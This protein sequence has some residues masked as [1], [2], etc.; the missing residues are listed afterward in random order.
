MR[1]LITSLRRD[2]SGVALVM[3][4]GIALIG[5]AVAGIVVTMA[6]TA[7]N[8]SGRDRTRTTEIH[9]AEGAVDATMAELGYSS[10]CPKPTFS[11]ITS[12]NGAQQ[13][14]VAVTIAYF[15]GAGAITCSA[16][17]PSRIPTTAVITATSTSPNKSIGLQPVRKLQAEVKLTPR[18]T[19]GQDAAVF[20]QGNFNTDAAFT[21]APA[22]AGQS[23]D[24]WV[25]SGS[26]NCGGGSSS[27]QI[28]GSL[29]MPAGALTVG[30]ANCRI[31]GNVWLQNGL[32]T[33]GTG[34]TQVFGKNLTVRSAGVTLNG[35]VGVAGNV[36]VGG[37]KGGGKD[38]IAG[39]TVN[40]GVGAAAIPN[41]VPVGLP[42]VNYVPSDWT[43][44]GFVIKDQN[45]FATA[46]NVSPCDSL[47][48]D[49]PTVTLPKPPSSTPTV[50]NLL[51]CSGGLTIQK[52]T[53]ALKADTAI[54]A[55][56]VTVTTK[57]NIV[58]GDGADHKL[59]IIVPYSTGSGSI[60]ANATS[61][62]IDSKI[63]SF[64]YAPG[65]IDINPSGSYRGQIYGGT[66]SIKNGNYFQ[67]DNVGVPG[68]QLVAAVTYENGYE[69]ALVYKREVS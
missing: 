41:L 44:K 12:G 10:P 68:V 51:G 69:V 25:D 35:D 31:D 34:G 54:F 57:L 18:V 29:Y 32:T 9:S 47:T 39:G 8:D 62:T 49:P 59:W 27:V 55:T 56:S 19:L 66:V 37:A 15:D 26:W 58:S 48:K 14:Q 6:I 36:I 46:A 64:W 3:A 53:I 38:I 17:V 33:S 24:I 22:V 67:Y 23:A 4:M 60:K 20:S 7:S 40:Y 45:D 16:G 5:I 43:A 52:A 30:G 63:S 21:L 13:T 65:T 11:P 1:T 2:E 42:K 50:Y 61:L 28:Q